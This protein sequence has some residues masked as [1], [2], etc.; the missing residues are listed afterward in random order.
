[1]PIVHIELLEGRSEEKKKRM[2]REVTTAMVRAL[3]IDED[4]VDIIVHEIKKK[5]W[6]TG[7]VSWDR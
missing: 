6:S 4:E 7:G 3:E 1:M 2:L 5:D